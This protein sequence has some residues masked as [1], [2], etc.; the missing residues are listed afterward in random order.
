[1]IK[2]ILMPTDGSETARKAAKYAYELAV[3]SQASV[4]L[5]HVIDTSV[6]VG[7]LSVPAPE[8]P[9]HIV[10]PLEDYLRQAAEL[11]MEEIAR[12]GAQCGV[13]TRK[14][15]RYGHPV[16]EIIGEAERS[17]ID[18]IVMGSHGKSVL[19]AALLGSVTFGVIHKDTK[20][21]VLIVR[22]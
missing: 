16:E 21:P 6:F 20:I 8:T 11:D 22:R 18:L 9:T 3:L 1:M 10:E 19:R 7:R 15:I 12:L 13:E 5:V 14:V 17:N 2:S 4:T